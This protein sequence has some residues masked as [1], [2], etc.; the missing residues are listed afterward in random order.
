MVHHIMDMVIHMRH[1]IMGMVIPILR[2]GTV[3][4]HTR[5]H[6]LTLTRRQQS[7]LKKRKAKS[8][9]R[10]DY[11]PEQLKLPVGNTIL[12]CFSLFECVR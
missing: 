9:K 2:H 4:M 3:G 11:R 10:E 8:K 6:M 5:I 7:L 1:L 12:F